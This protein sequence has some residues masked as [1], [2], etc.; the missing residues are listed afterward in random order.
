[1]SRKSLM[2]RFLPKNLWGDRI[3]GRYIFRRG[4]GR[5][6][7]FRPVKFNDHLFALK[8]SGACY[9]PLIQFVTDKEYA[10]LYVAATVGKEYVTETYHILRSKEDLKEFSVDRF[11][12]ILKPTHSSGEVLVCIDSF[13]PLDREKLDNWFSVNH[14]ERSREKIIVIYDRR[15]LSKNFFRR[16]PVYS[17][18]L[19]IF[20]VF[21]VFL[22]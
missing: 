22:K 9:D 20:C 7:E 4:L 18:G 6:P 1:M 13:S 5:D 10:K 12:C 19:Q 21:T 16:R 3:Y 11:P 17:K 14:Y 15:L 8:T 2:R